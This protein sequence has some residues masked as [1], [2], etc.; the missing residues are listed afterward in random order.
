MVAT[1][2]L[3]WKSV[4]CLH[5]WHY[6]WT[7]W[8]ELFHAQRYRSRRA[9]CPQTSSWPIH[10]L[11]NLLVSLLNHIY[12]MSFNINTLIKKDSVK[13]SVKDAIMFERGWLKVSTRCKSKLWTAVKFDQSE[14]L[15]D[16]SETLW[17]RGLSQS[18][19]SEWDTFVWFE[20]V[21]VIESID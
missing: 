17:Q 7:A 3:V 1:L 4:S 2:T 10:W 8:W 16:R 18:L 12:R 21:Q 6:W 11:S 15:C 5:P 14:Y 13:M 20:R 9:A 19:L